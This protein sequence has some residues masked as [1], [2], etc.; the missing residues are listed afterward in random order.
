MTPGRVVL[1]E[2]PI[3]GGEPGSVMRFG[4]HGY[5]AMIEGL[6]AGTHTLALHADGDIPD[7]GLPA[8][9]ET[10]IEVTPR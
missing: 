8:D 3:F 5:V 6:S 2:N 7:A 1:P 4:G 10:T 9:F